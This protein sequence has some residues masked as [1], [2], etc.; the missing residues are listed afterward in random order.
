MRL[1]DRLLNTRT[2]GGAALKRRLGIAF[3]G[4]A[5]IL[6]AAVG[7]ALYTHGRMA[8]SV[9]RT[10]GEL[11]PELLATLRLS[12]RS[13]QLTAAAPLLSGTTSGEELAGI[14]R[15]LR[16]LLVDL[17]Q[18]LN[19]LSAGTRESVTGR[20]RDQVQLMRQA[21]LELTAAHAERIELRL[22]QQGELVRLQRAHSEL[23][24]TVSP[25]VYGV[26]SLNQ[27]FAR[28]FERRFQASLSRLLEREQPLIQGLIELI[29]LTTGDG[30]PPGRREALR[31]LLERLHPLLGEEWRQLSETGLA[32]LQRDDS[33]PA[34]WQQLHLLA[35]NALTATQ[36][37]HAEAL[38]DIAV[39]LSGSPARLVENTTRELG[40]AIDI[41]SEGNLLFA[42]LSAVKDVTAVNELVILEERYNR[43]LETFQNATRAFSHIPLAQR[44]PVLADNVQRIAGYLPQA[45]ESDQ[46][47]FRLRHRELE[48]ERRISQLLNTQRELTARLTGLTQELV[49]RM[50]GETGQLSREVERNR[51][52]SSWILYSVGLVGLLLIKL[53]ALIT[54]QALQRRE[55]ALRQAAIVFEN[56]NEGILITDDA[57]NI[58]A[59]NP[60]FSEI[61]GY[62]PDEVIGR[63][64]RMFKADHQSPT[65]YEHMWQSLKESGHWQGEVFNQR[66][67]GEPYPEWLTI[68]S[69]KNEAGRVSHY[70]GVFSD[71][72]AIKETQARIYHLAHHDP[73]TDLPNRM[74][75]NDRLA[76]AM[77]RAQ[78]E[79]H[80]IAVLFL[81]LDRFKNINDTLGHGVG[82]EVL[83]KV[84][85]RLAQSVR[86]QDTVARLGGDEFMVIMEG[87]HHLQEVSL[88]AQK[89]LEVLAREIVIEKRRFFLSA[90]IGISLYPDDGNSVD[91]LIK[92]ADTAMYRAKEHGRNGFHFYTSEMTATAIEHYALEN[93]LRQGLERQEF[94]LH[95]QPQ[96]DLL[97][98][99]ITGLEA[100]LRWTHPDWG[101]V[102]PDRFIPIAEDAGLILPL[103]EW[104]LRTACR[105]ARTWLDAGLLDGRVAVNLSGQQI[106]RGD[107]EQV[108]TRVLAE[109]GLPADHLELEVTE[110]FIMH[111]PEQTVR[112][113]DNLR[114]MGVSLAIDDFGTGHSSLSYL[115][116]LPIHLLKIDRSFVRDLAVDPNDE[117]IARAIIAMGQALGLRVIAEGVE[118]QRQADILTEAGCDQV[119]GYF[120]A[121]PV[122]AE[123]IPALL[124]EKYLGRE[125]T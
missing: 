22:R 34:E 103:G 12:E 64:P 51:T 74:M 37:A 79:A 44:N 85:E 43:S 76:H 39:E 4:V 102:G 82:D 105:Q 3:I 52:T 58:Q 93:S 24:D 11:L 67:D 45:R 18:Q 62:K 33:L 72:S 114:A 78:R 21:L 27:L 88:V 81:D 38:Q 66:K 25:V 61:S 123:Q 59:V 77:E 55:Q 117:A 116:R 110:G 10:S 46:N 100:L 95:Y 8:G 41:K 13:A 80:R 106:T 63:N 42:L 108:V 56:T 113:L 30:A 23:I 101:T 107:L 50:Q 115:K 118:E 2:L 68:S 94:E 19:R 98:G 69:V 57:A 90:S 15:H 83:R 14:D 125:Y 91:E 109:T 16:Q 71:I 36:E 104:V 20:I 99:R 7:T 26:S 29:P 112:M 35:E 9:Q 122:P 89:L 119:Q 73:L 87:V 49:E 5:T 40:V 121:R 97:S 47:P 120:Y 32:L 28:R 111:Q 53:I 6:A 1:L 17:E 84:A 96:C 86:A 54:I 65:V 124:A 48:L 92:N 70:V 75:L 60:A 31:R